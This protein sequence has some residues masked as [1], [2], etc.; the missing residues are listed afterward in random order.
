MTAIIKCTCKNEQQD[1][2]YGQ[3]MRVHNK[4][5]KFPDCRC[6]VCLKINKGE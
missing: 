5:L 3:G 4:T 6:T 1:K 2:M